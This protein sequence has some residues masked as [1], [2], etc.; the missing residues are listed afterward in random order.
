M[1]TQFSF[2]LTEDFVLKYKEESPPWGFQDAGSNALGEITFVRT[3]SRRKED[4]TKEKWFE[5]CQRVIEG[6]YSIQ[7]DWAKSNRLPWNDRKA[8]ASAQEAFDRMFT[9]KWTP[10]GRGLWMM[11]TNLVMEKKNSAALQNCFTG[12]TRFITRDGIRTL[13]EANGEE[14]EVWTAS[15][16]E[17]ATV[18]SF[19]VQLV[20]RIT[21][22]PFGARSNHRVVETATPDHRWELKDGTVT[23]TL[24][25]NDVVPAQSVRDESPHQDAYIHGLIFADGSINYTYKNGEFSHMMR[26]CGDKA[27]EVGHFSTIH[28]QPNCDGDPVVYYRS[29][30]NMKALPTTDDPAYISSFIN[31]WAKFDGA[32]QSTGTIVVSTQNHEAADWLIDHAAIG[33]YTV[34]GVNTIDNETNFGP[35]SA[36]L[37]RVSLSPIQKFWT[38]KSIE[39]LDYPETVYCAVVPK[40]ERF[41][42]ASGVYTSNCAFV[43]TKDIDRNDPGD[44]FGWTMDALMLGI[45]V[46]FDTLGQDKDM[47]IFNP[48]SEENV[49]VVP[50]TREG[51][52][53]SLRLILNSYLRQNQMS[54]TF[55]YSEVRLAGE[56]IRG[57]GG[58]S[59]GPEPLMKLHEN[60]RKVIGGRI[61]EKLDSRAIVDIVNL[62]GTCVVS[63]NVRRSAT[64]SLGTPNDKDF[65]NLKNAEIFPERNSFDSENPGWAWMSNNSIAAEIGTKYEDYIDLIADNGEPGFIWLDVTRNWGRTIDPKDGKDYRI[66][67]FNP[68]LV[69]G[70]KL[71]T[72]GGIKEIQELEGKDFIVNNIDGKKSEASCWKSGVNKKV[73]SVNLKG[74]HHYEATEEHKWPVYR[75]GQFKKVK[76]LDLAPGDNLPN[77]ITKEVYPNGENGS[78]LEGFIIGWNLG[79]GWITD[80]SGKPKTNKKDSR[81]IGFIVAGQSDIDSGINKIITDFLG[82]LGSAS[83]LMNKTEINVNNPKLREMFDR[84]SVSNKKNGLPNSVWDHTFSDQYR[85]GLIDGLISS[86][87][88]VDMNHKRIVFSSAHKKITEDLSSL[89]GFFGIKTSIE[90]TSSI[91]SFLGNPEKE[92]FRHTLKISG[93]ENVCNFSEIISLTNT[94][95]QNKIDSIVRLGKKKGK[96]ESSF[97]EVKSVEFS[98]HAD[99][100]DVTVR[101]T[102]HA[103]QLDHCITGNCAEQPLESFELCVSGDT[104]VHTKNNGTKTIKS[105]VGKNVDIWNGKEWT[106]VTP[107]STGKNSLHRVTLSDGSYLD[108]TPKHQWSAK[109]KTESIFKKRT[110]EEL[111][112]GMILPEF[113]L[114]EHVGKR[115]EDA[116][117]WGWFIGDGYVDNG[118]A[119]AIVQ[120]HEAD[121]VFPLLDGKVR[122][123]RKQSTTDSKWYPVVLNEYIPIE[124]AT[125]IRKEDRIPSEV[126]DWDKQSLSEFFGGWIDTD[127]SLIKNPRTDHYVL[128]GSEGKLRDA[129]ILLRKIGVN[130]STL[131]QFGKLGDE[132]NKGVRSRDL[133]RLLVPSYEAE[134]ISTHLKVAKR[135]GTKYAKNN[136]HPLSIIDRSRKQKIVSIELIS[137]EAD[138]YCFTEPKTGMGVFGN[139]ITYQCTL[140]EVHLN[141]HE[142]KADFMRTLKFAYL[143]GKTV[144]LL[145]THWQQTNAIMQR[146]RRIG[147][148]LTGIASF[149]DSRGLPELR[150]WMD[151]GYGKIRHYDNKYSEWLCVRESIR[152]TTV[153]PSG[154][155]SILSGATPGVHWGPGGKY[156]L[157]AIRFGDSDPLLHLFKAAGYKIEKDV[158]SSNTQVVYF[159][160]SSEHER[161]EQEVS[162]FEKIGLA[163]T[164]QKYWSDNGVSVTLSF[165]KETETKNVAPALHMY[166]GQLKAVSF[167]PM[168][169][170]TYPQQ[171]YTQITQAEYE[172]HLGKIMKIDFSAIYDGVD[173]LEAQGERFCTNDVCVI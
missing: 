89:L 27:N 16:W 131:R 108:A 136:A 156:F 4:G 111:K 120:E 93:Y 76:T 2:H 65:I 63:G 88:S 64:L 106:E 58:T 126:F 73:Y 31:G 125:E 92:Y 62:I 158:V 29:A 135:F 169:N 84:F 40:T 107:F 165:D 163:A 18:N 123:I 43:S 143:Y 33:G 103:F 128:Y 85:V 77:L 26:L 52:V 68:S 21:F 121:T 5:V 151:E 38:V 153:K 129:Q 97:I 105:L 157:R 145:S 133:Y 109:T 25:I 100:W 60:I 146:N 75:D 155:V 20:Q 161:S 141:R 19:G 41:T 170:Q 114:T 39:P 81:Q 44:L 148:S 42:L 22:A 59:S 113:S 47:E 71:W 164:A 12:E 79:D 78:R 142:D 6:M 74:G 147:T 3:Y 54:V 14:V 35:R 9:L 67:G 11:G 116:Y 159:P 127:G 56:P 172:S 124:I 96:D 138:T 61:G 46:G 82:E 72:D 36:P 137:D 87:G 57:F 171:P 1:S 140:V 152:V 86:D 80:R 48:S 101:D 115:F 49:Y 119:I 45:G 10:P 94:D 149:A 118:Y 95:K 168:G 91:M 122:A 55:D 8:Q 167:L 17:K 34:I 70:T 37:V 99:V 69:A 160:I 13:A 144:T 117:R 28:Y 162:L 51:W 173:N 83:T 132:T 130:H 23:T 7:K 110:T 90:S 53:E 104:L 139:V 98:R 30:T 166:E 134:N 112:V 24:K 32:L 50:D 66:M 15:G 154:S 150:E 102:T